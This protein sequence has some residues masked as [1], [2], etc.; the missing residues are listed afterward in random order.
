MQHDGFDDGVLVHIQAV[1]R[2]RCAAAFL[3]WVKVRDELDFMLPQEADGGRNG[4]VGFAHDCSAGK[5]N[6]GH[7][8]TAQVK[9][10]VFCLHKFTL[11]AEMRRLVKL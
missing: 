9:A 4:V 3:V 8:T 7:L 10:A 2:M 6:S 11:C 5:K 1:C